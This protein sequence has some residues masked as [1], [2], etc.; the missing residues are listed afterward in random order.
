MTD[1]SVFAHEPDSTKRR[2]SED[3]GMFSDSATGRQRG[4]ALTPEQREQEKRSRGH[5]A[6]GPGLEGEIEIADPHVE[7]GL[8]HGYGKNQD[9]E[10]EAKQTPQNR[11]MGATEGRFRK[12][13]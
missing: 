9:K 12:N 10:Q 13:F 5:R 2:G 8:Q 4:K 6:G 1:K 3:D 7:R 11:A